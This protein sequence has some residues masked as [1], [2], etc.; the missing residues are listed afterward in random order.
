MKRKSTKIST[1]PGF[2]SSWQFLL[3]ASAT[4]V[5][6]YHLGAMGGCL[7]VLIGAVILIQISLSGK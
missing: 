2:F 4:L 7:S 6:T 5:L 1:K 3:T